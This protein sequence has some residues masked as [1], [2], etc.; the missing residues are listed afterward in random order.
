M[1]ANNFKLSKQGR[2]ASTISIAMVLPLV[3]MSAFAGSIRPTGETTVN[4]VN[5]V[6]V[7]N[8]AAPNSKGLSHNQYKNYDV[9]RAGAVLNNSLQAGQSQLAGQLE[10]NNQLTD[11]TASIILNEVVSKNPSLLLGQQEIFGM[12]ADYVLANPNG[13]SCDGCGFINTTRATLAVG[14][15]NIEQERLA[16][17]DI[18][19]RQSNTLTLGGNVNGD[20]QLDLLAPK[21]DIDGNV[22]STDAINVIT[23]RNQVNYENN[24]ASALQKPQ[25]RSQSR[26]SLDGSIVGS[27]Q[28]GRIRIHNTDKKA[29]QTL[30]GE[31]NAKESLQATSAGRLDVL[32]SHLTGGDVSLQGDEALNVRG[33]TN[34]IQKT[35]PINEENLE[36]DV[37]LTHSGYTQTQSYEGSSI[38]GDNIT[39]NG[40]DIQVAASQITGDNIEATG[41]KLQVSGVVTTNTT[42]K[43]DRKTKGGWFNE[44]EAI[45]RTQQHHQASLEATNQLTLH[46]ATDLDIAGSNL[47]ADNID[48]TAG[49][50]L[51]ATTELTENLDSQAN[52][53]QRETAAL[54]SGERVKTQ[55]SQHV[56]QTNIT[57]GKVTLDS[58][59]EQKLAAVNLKANQASIKS[60]GNLTVTASTSKNSQ[61][62]EENFKYWGGIGGGET[63]IDNHSSST[64]TGTNIQAGELTLDS[65]ADATIN[66]SQLTATDNASIHASKAVTITHDDAVT[67]VE[68]EARHGTAFNITDK[69][70]ISNYKQTT[71]QSSGVAGKDVSITGDSVSIVGSQ[72]NAKDNL[73]IDANTTLN[74]DIANATD[75]LETQSYSIESGVHAGY[76]PGLNGKVSAEIKG[77]TTTT[78]TGTGSAN[79]NQLTGRNVSL[80]AQDID[81]KGSDIDGTQTV[82]ISGNNVSTGAGKALV[83]EDS[84]VVNR[85]GPEAYIQ[86]GLS[87]V[88]VGLNIG[89][90]HKINEHREYQAIDS[91]IDAG[92]TASL[93][94]NEQLSNQG[95]SISASDIALNAKNVTN[96]ASHDS[97]VDRDVQAGGKAAIDAYFG[98]QP[99]V[100]GTLSLSAQGV[101]TTTE[102]TKAHATHLHA[103]DKLNVTANAKALDE[104]TAMTAKN[105]DIRAN[106]YE[107]TSAYDSKV[108]TTH[109]GK[110]N[111][112]VDASTNTFNDINIRVGGNGEYQYLQTGDAKAVKGSLNAD[113]VTITAENSAVAAQDAQAKDYQITAANEARIGQ[114]NDKQWKTQGGAKLGGSVGATIL[115]AAQSGTP[116]FSGNAGFN[117]LS[118]KDNQAQAANVT[119][120]N[121]KVAAAELA[122][123]DGANIT[124][125]TV[126]VTGKQANIAAAQDNHRAKGVSL[127]GNV[128]LTLNISESGVNGGGAGLGANL[129]VINETSNKAHGATINTE[130]LVVKADDKDNALRV[131]G[132]T[133]NANN[134]ELSNTGDVDVIA[135]K[136]KSNVGNFGIGG[137]VSVGASK[138]GFKKGSIDAHL[139][140]ETD[141]S[142]YYDLGNITAQQVAIDS[143]HDINL[144]SSVDADSVI[145][146]ASN[147][148]TIASAQDKVKKVNFNAGINVGGSPVKFDKNTT[149]KDV[150][151]AFQ[152]DLQNGSILG[153]KAGG[154]L[155][156]LVDHQQVT[157]QSNINANTLDAN[158]G[159]QTIDVN[160]AKVSA[161][162]AD[163]HG[164]NIH[165]SNNDDFVHTVGASA[166]AKI[167][168]L[169]KIV[170]S[171]IT[172]KEIEKPVKF[173]S[174]FEWDDND[175]ENTKASVQIN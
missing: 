33:V 28:S 21:V 139:N 74:T 27:M 101:G 34:K 113:Q 93:V 58:K 108:S 89:T 115:L 124:A 118:V 12:A 94:A 138:K 134:I 46:S 78:R 25:S 61:N 117:Y 114:N 90:D 170:D 73:S 125:N 13:I 164:A 66:A 116:S 122:Q 2:I 92:K 30:Q 53:Y 55:S 143:D 95:I 129:G 26:L 153:I 163:I 151:L 42:N 75:L 29:T 47:A 39:L 149:A 59:G 24:E 49:N 56:H 111:V 65:G 155:G 38:T 142:Q 110:G 9:S 22:S 119:A 44:D 145:L 8:I 99:I 62:D 130:S 100:G 171:A 63:N 41:K 102:T 136:S 159:S 7:V 14:T 168:N 106:E 160:A 103:T 105:I 85:T 91:S 70:H 11:K 19:D 57:G 18:G 167:P 87:G 112:S 51:T 23:G 107:G 140:V 152:G 36:D 31:L 80:T 5:Q 131:E 79:N 1:L 173:S 128:A 43:K 37:K 15:P 32:A 69:K 88:R 161:N 148:L 132:A 154:E 175:G 104:G 174:T 54:K 64:L 172:G 147:D 144:Q 40:G 81:L 16:G 86:G 82:A 20:R 109:A 50:N 135:A 166:S 6:D 137:N 83:K 84:K 96:Q 141:N 48:L 10:R 133:I 35:L 158:V 123:I 120:D 169:L 127:D 98:V 45:S 165:T 76:E 162:Q 146:D 126:N 156:F 68:Q 3:S 17:F 77:V 72:V 121:I 71:T 97:V 4:Q 67:Q 60:A 52:R 157:H 150:F